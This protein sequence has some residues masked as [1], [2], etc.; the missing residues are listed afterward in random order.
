MA[1]V[2]NSPGHKNGIPVEGDDPNNPRQNLGAT[3][4]SPPDSIVFG[5]EDAARKS[6]KRE[7]LARRF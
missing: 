2:S 7:K 4:L 3:L 6:K 5:R 1:G